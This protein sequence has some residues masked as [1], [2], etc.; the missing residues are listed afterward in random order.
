RAIKKKNKCG[1]N[2]QRESDCKI[3]CYESGLPP[4]ARLLYVVSDVQSLADCPHSVRGSPE[5][6]DQSD[7]NLSSASR[8]AHLINSF[9]NKFA[10]GGWHHLRKIADQTLAQ[11]SSSVSKYPE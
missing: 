11:L 2:E 8:V 5:R 10:C 1:D 4:R 6:C 7:G 9:L 3:D